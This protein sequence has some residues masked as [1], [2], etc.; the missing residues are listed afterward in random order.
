[1]N[2]RNEIVFPV[3]AT[4]RSICRYPSVRNQTY[5]LVEGA[6]REVVASLDEGL[7]YMSWN[8]LLSC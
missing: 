5:V 2:L 3:N 4:H 6:I 1:M 8:G 7:W